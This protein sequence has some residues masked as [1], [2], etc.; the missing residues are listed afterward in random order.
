M[1]R[2]ESDMN[3]IQYNTDYFFDVNNDELYPM[4]KFEGLPEFA[5]FQRDN[6]NAE[7]EDDL[8]AVSYSSNMGLN[9]LPPLPAEHT[10]VHQNFHFELERWAIFRALPG[11]M[12]FD[13]TL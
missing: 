2:N 8:P 6:Y 10:Y 12:H 3:V 4:Q 13:A 1:V 11:L 9:E 7:N 5:V